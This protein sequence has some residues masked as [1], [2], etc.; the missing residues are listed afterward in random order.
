MLEMERGFGEETGLRGRDAAGEP[1][2]AAPVGFALERF[3]SK[4]LKPG[5]ALWHSQTLPET[6]TSS[7]TRL[8]IR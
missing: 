2:S 6:P 7:Q 1:R 4:W 5:A 8:G 3:C